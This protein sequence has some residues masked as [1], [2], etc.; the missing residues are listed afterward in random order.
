MIFSMLLCIVLLSDL[1]MA[2]VTVACILYRDRWRS[3]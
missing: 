2:T 3:G 1:E